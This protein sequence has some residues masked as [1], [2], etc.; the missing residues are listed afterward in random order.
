MN[1]EKVSELVGESSPGG[2]VERLKDLQRK[3]EGWS[4]IVGLITFGLILVSLITIVF[5]LMILKGGLLIIPGSVAILLAVGTGVMGYFQTSSK[6]LKQK[7]AQTKLPQ[8]AEQV[9]LPIFHSPASVTE[10]TTGLLNEREDR[11]TD[12]ITS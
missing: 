10:Q 1:L 3:H 5:I 8:S 9:G 11:S 2:E 4:R 12:K 6:M 7:L